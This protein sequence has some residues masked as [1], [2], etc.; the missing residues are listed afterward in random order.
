MVRDEA[1]VSIPV[2]VWSARVPVPTV[3]RSMSVGSLLAMSVKEMAETHRGEK[4][5]FTRLVRRSL[6]AVPRWAAANRVRDEEGRSRAMIAVIAVRACSASSSSLPLAFHDRS[7]AMSACWA[8]ACA[9]APFVEVCPVVGLMLTRAREVKGTSSAGARDEAGAIVIWSAAAKLDRKVVPK[10]S[11]AGQPT[12]RR[13]VG[14]KSGEA[15]VVPLCPAEVAEAVGEGVAEAV[16]GV[17]CEGT[18]AA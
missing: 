17:E 16:G 4:S 3:S 11:S 2:F 5:A 13:I 7:A 15:D 12:L 9:P 10:V 18:L 8:R 1:M 14:P 6:I